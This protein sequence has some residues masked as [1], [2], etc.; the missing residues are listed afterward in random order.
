MEY[1][2]VVLA[3]SPNKALAEKSPEAWEALIDINGRPMISYVLDGLQEA[4]HVGTIV[5]VGPAVLEPEVSRV[6][7]QLVPSGDGLVENL[8]RGVKALPGDARA[9]VV[10]SDIPLVSG[11]MIDEFLER[12]SEREGQFFYSVVPRP[13]IEARFPSAR[14]T[15]VRLKEG[16]VTGGNIVVIDPSIL[17][18]FRAVAERLAQDRKKPVALA[19][20]LGWRFLLGLLLGRLDIPSLEKRVSQ[21]F[22]ITARAVVCW[23]PEIGMDVDKPSDL[24][25]AMGALRSR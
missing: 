12:C 15:Y 2:A 24:E 25:V 18:D 6:G 23:D 9:L 17:E 10:T 1:G 20:L 19:R 3:G 14:R 13:A 4:R 22:H 16:G 7:G 21:V 11:G 8:S 5:V